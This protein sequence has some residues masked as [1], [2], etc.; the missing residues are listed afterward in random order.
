[1]K[2]D[3]TKELSN[4]IIDVDN[5]CWGK[6]HGVMGRDVWV[7]LIKAAELVAERKSNHSIREWS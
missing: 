6:R 4:A 3:L 5:T 2:I 1:M 7:E